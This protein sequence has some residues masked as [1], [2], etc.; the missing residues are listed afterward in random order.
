MYTSHE[1][2]KHKY[3][4]HA[5]QRQVWIFKLRSTHGHF[6]SFLDSIDFETGLQSQSKL[7]F[8]NFSNSFLLLS[9]SLSSFDLS[10]FNRIFLPET[11][12][13]RTPSSLSRLKNFESCTGP[14]LP[15]SF[16][17]YIWLPLPGQTQP[18]NKIQEKSIV[19]S[20]HVTDPSSNFKEPIYKRGRKNY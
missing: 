11:A 16:S 15:S 7:A 3:A 13:R 5:W 14:L 17:F 18:R 20:H 6:C 1:N 19:P 12:L 8:K 4:L 10:S 9:A 2:R